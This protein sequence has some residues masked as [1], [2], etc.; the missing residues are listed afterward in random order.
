MSLVEPRVKEVNIKLGNIIGELIALICYYKS[1]KWSGII[2][3]HLKT[4]DIDGVG[5]L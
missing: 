4:S 3:L 2:K 1:T 5:L